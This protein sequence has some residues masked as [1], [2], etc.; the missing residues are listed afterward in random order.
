MLINSPNILVKLKKETMYVASPLNPK[1]GTEYECVGSILEM[2]ISDDELV[3]YIIEENMFLFLRVMLKCKNEQKL[4]PKEI[5]D[6]G[7]LIIKLVE[8]VVSGKANV[9]HKQICVTWS[10]TDENGNKFTCCNSYSSGELEVYKKSEEN[11]TYK[12]MW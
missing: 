12:N 9:S 5:E 3:D 1:I 7:S 10:N 2:Y 4:T 11:N 6:T 8:D